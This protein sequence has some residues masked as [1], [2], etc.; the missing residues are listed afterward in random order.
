MDGKIEER[1]GRR[2]LNASETSDRDKAAAT[3]HQRMRQA[4][5]TTPTPP[6]PA[7]QAGPSAD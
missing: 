1:G 4:S 2:A 6:P 7:S 3:L 5:G